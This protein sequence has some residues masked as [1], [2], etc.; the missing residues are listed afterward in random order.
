VP[1]GNVLSRGWVRSDAARRVRLLPRA[2][3]QRGVFPSPGGMAAGQASW[4]SGSRAPG[5]SPR[6]Q[7]RGA[8]A[9]A[10]EHGEDN[11]EPVETG[12]G[13]PRARQPRGAPGRVASQA[14]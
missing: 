12:A 9:A 13:P 10:R 2:T 6:R 14:E 4:T 11:G 7:R 3:L 8:R 1:S 5:P